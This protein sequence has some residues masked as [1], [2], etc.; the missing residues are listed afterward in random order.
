MWPVIEIRHEQA[1]DY[2][3]IDEKAQFT[4]SKW[5]DSKQKQQCCKF[6]AN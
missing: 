3:K 5:T 4:L 1:P 2:K 6:P